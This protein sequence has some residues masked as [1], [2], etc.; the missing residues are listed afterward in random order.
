[1]RKTGRIVLFLLFINAFG[2][3]KKPARESDDVLN[4]DVTGRVN[5]KDKEFRILHLMSYHT[6]WEW[7]DQQFLG[8]KTAL[9]ELKT[10][11]KVIA[12]NQKNVT[13]KELQQCISKAQ[14][15]IKSW[16]PDLVYT[17]DDYV[18][19]AIVKDYINT[20]LPFV[21]SGVNI[22]PETYGFETAKN[23]TGI[24]EQELFLPTVELL[25]D[26][27]P[28]I[29]TLAIITDN[30]EMWKET[31]VRMQAA[32]RDN[33][34]DIRVIGWDVID[35]FREYKEKVTAYQEQVDA[36]G[37]LGIFLFK[38]EKGNHVAFEDVL[39]WTADNSRLP[40]FSFWKDRVSQGTLCAVPV[41]AYEQGLAAGKI[42]YAVL[43]EN[44]SPADFPA[45]PTNK[46]LPVISLARARR[47]GLNIDSGILLSVQVETKFD[48][49]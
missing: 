23:I 33:L 28:G 1:M 9:E 13:D 47:L 2:C 21:Y 31:L 11:Y 39:R 10:E 19:E 43:A 16:K 14:N 15:L 32:A 25:S 17:S 38:D 49:E 22:S 24:L 40:D 45:R 48:W 26:I 12:F 37:F 20:A 29:R 18:Q 6:L 4:Q 34:P 27:V 5:N 3:N 41:S 42:A 7:T 36:I 8:F 30:G 44:R 46:G 35:T